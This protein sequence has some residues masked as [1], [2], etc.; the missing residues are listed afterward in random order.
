MKRNPYAI[1]YAG[2]IK[3]WMAEKL[4]YKEEFL[5]YLR[6]TLF[7]EE[8]QT[9]FQNNVPVPN[10]I[11]IP[12]NGEMVDHKGVRVQGIADTIYVDGVMVKFIN[13]INRKMPIGTKRRAFVRKIANIFIK[14]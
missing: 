13:M 12:N 3:P 10:N 1:A 9:I 6:Q 8:V 2:N 7:F 5:F 14:K 4:D 11:S